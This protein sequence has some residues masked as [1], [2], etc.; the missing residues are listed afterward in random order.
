MRKH[1]AQLKCIFLGHQLFVPKLY[2]CHFVIF[3]LQKTD[4][5]SGDLNSVPKGAHELWSELKESLIKRPI[6]Q[7]CYHR[8]QTICNC[9]SNIDNEA[10]N[11]KQV[12]ISDNNNAKDNLSRVSHVHVAKRDM[13]R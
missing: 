5:K 9:C 12:K 6:L 8:R 3:L 10:I 1:N 2:Y 13:A 11:H 7:G 4:L